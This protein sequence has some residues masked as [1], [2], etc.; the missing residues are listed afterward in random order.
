MEKLEKKLLE[1]D[2]FHVTYESDINHFNGTTTVQL[3]LSDIQFD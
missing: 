3:V 1:K 2:C